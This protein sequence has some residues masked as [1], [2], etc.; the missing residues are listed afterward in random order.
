EPNPPP[1]LPC[2][3]FGDRQVAEQPA[4][5]VARGSRGH[6]LRLESCGLPIEMKLDLLVELRVGLR[7]ADK[8]EET[9]GDAAEHAIIRCAGSDPTRS[10]TS[11]RRAVLFRAV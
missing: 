1:R 7:A 9:N 10:R 3:F 2:L 5:R 8:G 4:G 11:P 6:A